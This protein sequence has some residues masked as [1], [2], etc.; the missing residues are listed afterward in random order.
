MKK[1]LNQ[2]GQAAPQPDN[3][4]ALSL[5]ERSVWMLAEYEGF[6]SDDIAA[7]TGLS[8]SEATRTL[9]AARSKMAPPAAN[10]PGGFGIRLFSYRS[11]A[12]AAALSL[13]IYGFWRKQ[14]P[15]DTV[16]LVH[17]SPTLPQPTQTTASP[18]QN[19][20]PV[21]T[22]N[23][24]QETISAV[25]PAKKLKSA[26]YKPETLQNPTTT[27]AKQNSNNVIAGAGL[28][29]QEISPQTEPEKQNIAVRPALI[30]LLPGSIQAVSTGAMSSIQPIAIATVQPN[31][32]IAQ[33][34]TFSRLRHALT[35]RSLTDAEGNFNVDVDINIPSIVVGSPGR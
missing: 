10:K 8:P 24:A 26:K 28:P 19:T 34:S 35:P 2:Q 16:P 12:I 18:S 1:E 29:I 14:T 23:P 15:V 33:Q 5:M 20:A 4:E 21:A 31:T 17:H 32:D 9:E 3:L 11:M 30:A 22:N 6:S 25:P 7:I 27:S 13:L